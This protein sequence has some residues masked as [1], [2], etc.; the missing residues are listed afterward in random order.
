MTTHDL[1]EMHALPVMCLAEVQNAAPGHDVIAID[2]GQFLPGN[3]FCHV[4]LSCTADCMHAAAMLMLS[5]SGA[6]T[7]PDSHSLSSAHC[8][9]SGAVR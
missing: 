1:A 6:G 4:K 5:S 3:V 2:E 7:G 9:R 8:Y